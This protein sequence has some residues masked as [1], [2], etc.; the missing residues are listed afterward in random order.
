MHK[1]FIYI[2]LFISLGCF[3]QGTQE[4]DSLLNVIKTSNKLEDKA[5]AHGKLALLNLLSDIQFAKK[6]LDSSFA[7]YTNINNE[8]GI[9]SSHL[10]LAVYYRLEGE[11]EKGL[12]HI[13]YS[14][15]YAEKTKD[16]FNIANSLFQKAVLYS[17][18]SDYNESLE[19]FYKILAIY[20]AMDNQG[21]VGLTIKFHWHYI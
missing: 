18:K 4:A 7:L 6:H 11:Y 12:N 21:K 3:S 17:L 15:D 20:E 8:K 9:A 16:T 13:K 10:K 1:Y 14:I 19:V 2:F 5:R